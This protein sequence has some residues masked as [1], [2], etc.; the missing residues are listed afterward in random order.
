[1]V[2]NTPIGKDQPG[3]GGCGNGG[4]NNSSYAI[5]NHITGSVGLFRGTSGNKSRHG[6][7][8]ALPVTF[9]CRKIGPTYV[10][11]LLLGFGTS[12]GFF[13]KTH[14]DFTIRKHFW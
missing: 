7:F 1:M 13:A 10:S 5:R 2:E 11:L 14:D 6:D 8:L 3:G 9:I 12:E 4:N